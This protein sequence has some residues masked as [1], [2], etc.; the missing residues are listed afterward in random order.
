MKWIESLV[1]RDSGKQA[2]T[3]AVEIAEH[4]AAVGLLPGLVKVKVYLNA[5]LPGD[6]KIVLTWDTARIEKW[7]SDAAALLVKALKEHGLVDHSVWVEK[8]KT[9]SKM[10][11]ANKTRGNNQ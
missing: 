6:L 5:A 11:S 3:L 10:D 1:V 2:E 7:G 8:G 4:F 9:S